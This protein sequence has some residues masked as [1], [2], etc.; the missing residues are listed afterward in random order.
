MTRQ[1]RSKYRR[2]PVGER[3]PLKRFDRRDLAILKLY[4][5]EHQHDYL[6]ADTMALV[7]NRN[8]SALYYR[9]EALWHWAFI[10]K[11]FPPHGYIGGSEKGVYFLGVQG[12]AKLRQLYNRKV[13]VKKL[14]VNEYHPFAKHS[15]LVNR[16]RVLTQQAVQNYAGLDIPYEFRDRQFKQD[17]EAD[18]PIERNGGIKYYTI[19]Y[20]IRPDWF[21]GLGGQGRPV[22]NFLVELQRSSRATKN[23]RDE[24]VKKVRQKYEAYYYLYKNELWRDWPEKKSEIKNA[25]D[26]RVLTICDMKE[27]EFENLI[28]LVRNIDERGKGLRLFL[29]IRLQDLEDKIST[30]KKRLTRSGKEVVEKMLTQES[31]MNFFEPIWRTSV[32]GEELVSIL[33]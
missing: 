27:Q 2:P 24:A 8:L 22:S 25:K 11:W 3:L 15:V 31:L 19:R 29:F 16:V 28:E 18:K 21:F 23:P 17:F 4:G 1:R 14:D 12:E 33:T 7:L 32:A 9:L 20:S 6:H 5:P 30:T 13:T 10:E 26:F